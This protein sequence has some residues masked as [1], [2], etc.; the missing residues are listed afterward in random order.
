MPITVRVLEA[1][2]TYA[3]GLSIHT[4][5]SG[6]VSSI[7]ECYLHLSRDGETVGLG[8]IRT[9]PQAEEYMP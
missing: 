5:A 6:P 8:E 4:A 9:N 7:R 2:L 3:D 1:Q